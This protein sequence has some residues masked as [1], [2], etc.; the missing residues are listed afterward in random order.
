MSLLADVEGLR[1]LL[2]EDAGSLSDDDATRLL[3]LATGVVQAAAGQLLVEVVDDTITLMGTTDRWLDLPQRPV[4][5]V[6]S[7]SLEDEPVTDYKRFGDRL[8]RRHGWARCA[9]EPA[10]VE[11]VY[12]HGFP[13][14]DAKL[15]L[16]RSAVLAVA[17]KMNDNPTGATGFT[18]DDYSQQY[19][20]SSTSDLAGLIP[21]NLRR[22]LR[23]AYG[24]R[25]R[26]VRIG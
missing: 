2:K 7:I 11:V 24:A 9:D 3:E 6:T 18:I 12:T 21:D 19:G 17:A 26:L 5:T 15:A 10:V 14:W 1:G 13:D 25:G 23:R 22:S 4:T 20:Q 16:A 8:W